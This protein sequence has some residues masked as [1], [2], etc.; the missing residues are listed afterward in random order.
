MNKGIGLSRGRF[1]LCMN[2]DVT[3]DPGFI[4]EALKGFSK[5]EHV[6]MVSGKILRQDGKTIDSTGLFLTAQRKACERGYGIEDKGQFAREGSIFG[7][8]GAAAFYRREMLDDIKLSNGW[9]DPAFRIFYEDLDVAWRAQRK[10]WR[11]YYN[12]K[13]LAYHVRGGS[14]RQ[15]SGFGR[16]FARQYLSDE[17]QVDLIKNRYL[18]VMRNESLLSF[19]MFLVP[20]V[21]HEACVWGYVLFFKPQLAVKVWRA[22]AQVRRSQPRSALSQGVKA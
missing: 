9:F 18:L 11:G 19:L 17:L 3:L 13:A 6:G 15:E 20:I 16:S 2:D 5:A 4:E 22:L 12:P 21:F 1:I 8:S 14:V 7:V 10:G